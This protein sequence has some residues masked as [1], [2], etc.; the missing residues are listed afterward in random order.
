LNASSLTLIGLSDRMYRLPDAMF[1]AEQLS[2]T[3]PKLDIHMP[4]MDGHPLPH[5]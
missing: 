5:C 2:G 4:G 3:V 1:E